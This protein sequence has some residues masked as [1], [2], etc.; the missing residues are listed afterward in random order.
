MTNYQ[1]ATATFYAVLN[2]TNKKITIYNNFTT[3]YTAALPLAIQGVNSGTVPKNILRLVGLWYMAFPLLAVVDYKLKPIIYKVVVK[4]IYKLLI[5]EVG[6][7]EIL[8]V[9]RCRFVYRPKS[10]VEPI[11]VRFIITI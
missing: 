10:L 1:L 5:F 9:R 7:T 11:A 6:K 3:I 2:A 4:I 8:P